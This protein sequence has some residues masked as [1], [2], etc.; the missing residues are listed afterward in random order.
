MP[1]LIRKAVADDSNAIWATR[2]AAILA[3]CIG[4]YSSSDLE[5]W[6]DGA[7]TDRFVQSVIDK[8][9]VAVADNRVVGTGIIDVVSGH[10]DAVFVQPEMMRRGV[11]TSMMNYLERIAVAYG[12]CRL[13]LDSTLN[14]VSFYRGC[15]FIG[16]QISEYK[17][18]RGITLMCIP[19]TK[20]LTATV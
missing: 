4:F 13:T 1:F 3:Q 19:M 7:P 5:V 9:H 11:G 15:G 18:P 17:S 8:W 6:T 20:I 12:L 2:N 14:A 16:E 10:I